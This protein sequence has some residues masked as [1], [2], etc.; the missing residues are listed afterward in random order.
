MPAKEIGKKTSTPYLG[1]KKNQNSNGRFLNG[2]F[3]KS[4]G[5]FVSLL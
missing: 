5:Q 1:I 3:I 2:S 4:F